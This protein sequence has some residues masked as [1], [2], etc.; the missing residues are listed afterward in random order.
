MLTYRATSRQAGLQ[1][2]DWYLALVLAGASQQGMPEAY[3]DRL[4]ERPFRQDSEVKRKTRREAL[5]ALVAADM[6]HVLE[7]LNG[8]TAQPRR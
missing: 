5:E 6:L 8:N 1:P 2:Y 7:A 3:I 4:R